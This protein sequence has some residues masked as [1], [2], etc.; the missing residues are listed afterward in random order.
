MNGPS[1]CVDD[2]EMSHQDE[3]DTEKLTG[4]E[5]F[6]LLLRPLGLTEKKLVPDPIAFTEPDPLGALVY[7][8]ACP[9][10]A[11][12]P[13]GIISFCFVIQRTKCC[14]LKQNY[15]TLMHK[16]M[17]FKRYRTEKQNDKKQK[18]VCRLVRKLPGIHKESSHKD[19]EAYC[20]LFFIFWWM[21]C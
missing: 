18:C 17:S 15:R 1:A 20:P 4:L 16:M 8:S 19:S 10:R 9:S 12:V 7:S 5:D 6:G 2:W 3:Y 21:V 11:P 13:K 14:K